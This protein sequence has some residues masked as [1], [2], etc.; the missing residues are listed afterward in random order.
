MTFISRGFRENYRET[1]ANP[2]RLMSIFLRNRFE[3]SCITI[4]VGIRRGEEQS[5]HSP[6]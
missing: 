1:L 6:I 5:P 2:R 4:A 3:Q